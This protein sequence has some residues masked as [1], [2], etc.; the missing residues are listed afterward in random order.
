MKNI[1]LILRKRVR[2][3]RVM[4]TP[5]HNE[6]NGPHIYQEELFL[7]TFEA[8]RKGSKTDLLVLARPLLKGEPTT[9]LAKFVKNPN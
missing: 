1:I 4:V 7:P 6:G 5:R 8:G 3:V 9:L 2:N